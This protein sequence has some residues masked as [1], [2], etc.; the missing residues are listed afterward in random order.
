MASNEESSKGKNTVELPSVVALNEIIL[1]SMV[2]KK[3]ADHPW[4]DLEIG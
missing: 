4:H 3:H 1:S 2:V